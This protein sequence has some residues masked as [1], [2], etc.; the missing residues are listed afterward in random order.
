[1]EHSPQSRDLLAPADEVAPPA[2]SI[3]S[4][5]SDWVS[6]TSSRIRLTTELALAEAKLAATSVALMMF[7]ALLA[8][9]FVLG[10]WGLLIAGLVSGL[11]QALDAPLWAVLTGLCVLHVVLAR[12]LWSRVVRLTK[13]LEFSATRQQ[14]GHAESGEG[15]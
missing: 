2:A 8:A 4:L 5:V 1:M 12:W 13:H 3:V 11:V 14:F 7:F 6:E 15:Q 9:V 10:A